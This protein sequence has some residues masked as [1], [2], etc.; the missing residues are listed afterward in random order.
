[1]DQYVSMYNLA[2]RLYCFGEQSYTGLD[3]FAA[4]GQLQIYFSR[5][6]MQQ[7]FIIIII[8]IFIFNQDTHITAVLFSGVQH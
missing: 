3:H 7:H 2:Q 5:G 1:M 4:C 8:N 6:S